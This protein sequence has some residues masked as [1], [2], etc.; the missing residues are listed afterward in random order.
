MVAS[1]DDDVALGAE[2]AQA[3]HVLDGDPAVEIGRIAGGEVPVRGGV[4][5]EGVRTEALDLAVVEHPLDR[6]TGKAGGVA[7]VLG[8]SKRRIKPG[9]EDD[10]GPRGILPA[11]FS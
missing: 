11:R 2:L 5:A 9:V 1:G 8:L 7:E 4:W 6:V 10:E 3:V